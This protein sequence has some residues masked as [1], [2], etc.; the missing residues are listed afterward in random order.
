MNFESYSRFYDGGERGTTIRVGGKGASFSFSADPKKDTKYRLFT[1]GESEQCY[2][3]KD[4]PDGPFQ[5]RTIADALDTTHAVRERYCLNFSSKQPEEYLRRI[6]KK[7]M[8]TDPLK[9]GYMSILP[10]HQNWKLGVRVTAKNLT[11]CEG[12][13][14]QMRIDIRKK[15]D[16]IRYFV[17]ADSRKN[18]GIFLDHIHDLS[19]EHL[20]TGKRV[21]D[22]IYDGMK[23]M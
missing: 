22:Y 12:G 23:N 9:M 21:I 19:K 6:Y 14:L 10:R 15:K 3:W 5:Y 13:Y 1:T 2:W 11:L 7:I 17:S 18:L 16:G 8:W 4:E 20:M